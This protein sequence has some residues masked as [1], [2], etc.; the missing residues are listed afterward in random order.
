MG[1]WA[2]QR[3]VDDADDV[4]EWGAIAIRHLASEDPDKAR[5]LAAGAEE[6]LRGVAATAS[7]AS[8]IAKS[9]ARYTLRNGLGLWR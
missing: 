3:A 8:G 1:R 2:Q 7:E 6:V 9:N 5:W 4:A